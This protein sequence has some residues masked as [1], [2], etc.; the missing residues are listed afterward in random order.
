MKLDQVKSKAWECYDKINSNELSKNFIELIIY[1]LITE[2]GKDQIKKLNDRMYGVD[3]EIMK[4]DI[5]AECNNR[6]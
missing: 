4:A 6:F 1:P 3:A 5:I 2:L